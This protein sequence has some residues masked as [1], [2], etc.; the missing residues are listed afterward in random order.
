MSVST[1]SIASRNSARL[2]GAARTAFPFVVV[3]AAWEALAHAGLFPPRL[4]PPLET[5]AAAL[6]R[7]TANGILLHHAAE[8]VLRLAAGFA[9][10]TLV[11]VALGIVMGRSRP[12]GGT[13]RP[14]A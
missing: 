1:T 13:P 3:G 7:L 11:G 8:T 9:L 12:P 10:A 4:F 14:P 2:R 6:A 5:V